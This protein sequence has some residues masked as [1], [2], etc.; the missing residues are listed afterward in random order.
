MGLS[1]NP[2][3]FA[4]NPLARV[5]EKRTD[6]AWLASC[7]A[8]PAT[9][10]VPFWRLKPFIRGDEA[11]EI[12]WLSPERLKVQL[13]AG[14]PCIL[15]GERG[16]TVHFALDVESD[17]D[18]SSQSPF[19][20]GGAFS[21]LRDIAAKLE[22]G[23]AA[24][25]AQAKSLIDWHARHG[26]CAKC[27]EKTLLADAGYKRVCGTCKTEHFPHTDPV[28]ITLV[29]YG[30]RCLLGRNARF[31]GVMYS[32]LA[33]FIEPGE[34]IEE[35]VVREIKEEVGV[36]VVNV[37]YHSTQPW[38]YPSSLMNGCIAEALDDKV[39]VDGDEIEAAIWL[40]R[41]D[42]K[43]LINGERRDDVRLPPPMAIAHQLIRA[44]AF[45]EEN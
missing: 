4:N 17:E 38:P 32:A 43:R 25:L 3:T 18:P 41:G 24:I 26:F 29:A 15:L 39:E 45:D 42:V 35:A 23:E 5:A 12:G 36:D 30:D 33:G 13:D 20:G 28:V 7:L 1:R 2:N 19:D 22:P 6:D 31:P 14:A 8:D 37:R 11:A 9:R 40:T 10:L 27:G 34:S 44:W 16:G 21:E